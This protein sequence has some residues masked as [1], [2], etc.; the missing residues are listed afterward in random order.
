M[1]IDYEGE[2]YPFEFDDITVKQAMKIEKHTGLSLT[3]WGD[4]LAAEKGMNLAALQALGWL[5][6]S[7]GAGAVDD[8]D[9]KLTKFGDAFGKALAVLAA[10][11]KAAEPAVPTAAVPASNGHSPA[12]AAPV[13]SPASSV[14]ASP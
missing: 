13:L 11:Q 9:F 6:L 2:S 10:E 12:T 7:G 1:N 4:A 5:V 8:A 3:D 14:P